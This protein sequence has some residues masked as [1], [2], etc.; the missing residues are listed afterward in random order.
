VSRGL[1]RTDQRTGM[2][3]QYQYERDGANV[4]VYILDT[5]IFVENDQFEGCASLG[6]D[7]TGEGNYDGHG[8]GTHVAGTLHY[9]AS[10]SVTRCV[11][12]FLVTYLTFFTFLLFT[13]SQL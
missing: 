8:H 11:S 9:I 12:L 4:D 13:Q 5:G 10:L 6:P 7:Y 2:N 1:D 3:D